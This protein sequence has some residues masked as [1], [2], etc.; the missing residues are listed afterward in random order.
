M[1]VDAKKL[2]AQ[3]DEAWRASGRGQ[4]AVLADAGL[5]RSSLSNWVNGNRVPSLD[6]LQRYAEAAEAE[7]VIEVIPKGKGQMISATEGGIE[8]ARIFDA[9]PDD[10]EVG[11]SLRTRVLRL[12]RVAPLFDG[13]A[14]GSIMVVV[15]HFEAQ[16]NGV[17]IEADPEPT[18][19]S[20]RRPGR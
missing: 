20:I 18:T 3:L 4:K 14:W 13:R 12:L 1:D 11:P 7:L 15:R 16:V 17:A 2:K 19:S 10:P 9:L 6:A 8:A 5:T